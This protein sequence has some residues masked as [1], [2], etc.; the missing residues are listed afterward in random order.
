MKPPFGQ[1]ASAHVGA[2]VVGDAVV[3]EV[4]APH[5]V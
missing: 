1:F 5:H 4:V 3:G 2:P